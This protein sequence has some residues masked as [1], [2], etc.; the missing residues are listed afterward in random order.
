MREKKKGC[1]LR[2]VMKERRRIMP[3]DRKRSE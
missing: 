3:I 2:A 1:V